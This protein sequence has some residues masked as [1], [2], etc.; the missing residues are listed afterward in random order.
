MAGV[1][2]LLERLAQ[3]LVFPP[4]LL[5]CLHPPSCCRVQTIVGRVLVLMPG[6]AQPPCF[7]I[8]PAES[9]AREKLPWVN[10]RRCC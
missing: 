9:T 10:W 6:L 4:Q 8:A 1:Q 3:P 5:V 7:S 2:P